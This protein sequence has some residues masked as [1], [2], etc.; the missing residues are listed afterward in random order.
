MVRGESYTRL[1][2]L[3]TMMESICM[4][5]PDDLAVGHSKKYNGLVTSFM[6]S[7]Y[8]LN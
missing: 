8:A 3:L 5:I 7:N 1:E 6:L 2:M 4:Q